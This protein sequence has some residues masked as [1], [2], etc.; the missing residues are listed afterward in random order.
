M[1]NITL[2]ITAPLWLFAHLLTSPVAKPFPGIY[3]NNV[4]LVS[5]LDLKILPMSITL[6][7][8]FPS[9]LMALP[10]SDYI[11]TEM[12]QM[13]IALWQAFPLL[14]VMIHRILYSTTSRLTNYLFPVEL[15]SRP[16]T[17]QGTSYLHNVK[18]IYRFVLTLCIT[19]HLPILLLTLFPASSLPSPSLLDPLSSC[20]ILTLIAQTP[21]SVFVPNSLCPTSNLR[22]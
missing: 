20:P 12:H 3:A 2:T 15:H 1:Q 6:S 21:F 11:T 16:P 14:T 22:T 7:Y 5:P 17:P 19:T 18:H 9:I 8:L 4:L 13:L 10:C